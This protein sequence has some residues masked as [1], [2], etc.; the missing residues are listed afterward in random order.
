[1]KP[2]RRLRGWVDK[3]L[4]RL[5]DAE[6]GEVVLDQRRVFILPS[7]AGLGFATLLTILFIGSVNYNLSLG[8]G[9]TFL[10]AGCAVVDMHLTF[11]NLAY[12]YLSPGRSSPVFAGEEARFEL[13]LANRRPHDRF[14]LWIGF[15]EP[16]F[17]LDRQQTID[18]PAESTCNVTLL[19][20]T[21]GRGWLEAPR[22]RLSTRFPLGLLCAWSY[23]R[24]ALRTLVYPRPE[25]SGPPLPMSGDERSDGAGIGGSNDFSGVRA[26]RVGDSIKHLAWRQI[27]RI[28][29]DS[30]GNLVTK[31]FEGGASS[32]LILDFSLLPTSLDVEARLS[33]MTRWI[34]EAESRGIP[35]GFRLGQETRPTGSGPSHRQ[36]CLRSLALY[37]GH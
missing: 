27:A 5:G 35:Y 36:E 11:R 24:P 15:S 16:V 10:I 8:L 17:V 31:H 30:G 19:T 33:R 20:P 34:L 1:M 6:A 14:A 32:D 18:I 12:L 28:D 7:K 23:W 4:F 22:I 26:Y 13:H 9:M 29:I 2:L 25:Q 3:W 37:E 21:D